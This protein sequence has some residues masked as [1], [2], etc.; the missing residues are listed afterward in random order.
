MSY[1]PIGP[2]TKASA[3]PVAFATDVQAKEVTPDAQASVAAYADVTG[4]ELDT[5]YFASVSYTLVNATQTITYQILGA[6]R[7]DYA[8]AVV[9]QSAD[10]LAA[11]VATYAV[12]QA[13]YRY[14][15]VQIKDK[16]GGVHGTTGV[17]GLAK[18]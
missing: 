15:K 6:N 9:I 7:A 1:L 17:Y 8:D 14:Y 10:I 3:V 2:K 18:L 11:G 5:L 13:P 4:S 12:T 16:V